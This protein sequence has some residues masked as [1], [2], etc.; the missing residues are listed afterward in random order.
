[1][2]TATSVPPGPR[3]RG[4]GRIG[5]YHAILEDTAGISARRQNTNDIFVGLNVVF[6][7]GIGFLLTSTH[8]TSW[9]PTITLAFIS[10]FTYLLNRIWVRTLKDYSK[11][12]G[13]RHKYI[14]DLEREFREEHG[15]DEIGMFLI[16]GKELYGKGASMQAKE[17]KA[18]VLGFTTLELRMARLLTWAYPAITVAAGIVTWMVTVGVVP[19]VS[20]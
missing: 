18:T 6:L 7:T 4:Y 11:L 5:E 10:I 1:M 20:L 3:S 2:G 12:L 9:F 16:I 13:V 19:P 14:E 8:F 15:G 17:K